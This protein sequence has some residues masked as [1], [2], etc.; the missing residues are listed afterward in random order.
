[1]IEIF[2]KFFSIVTRNVTSS[3]YL[4]NIHYLNKFPNQN[5][6]ILRRGDNAIPTSERTTM[7]SDFVDGTGFIGILETG[8]YEVPYRKDL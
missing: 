7:W 2:P 4:N 5:S 3:Q 6:K 1:M 8:S